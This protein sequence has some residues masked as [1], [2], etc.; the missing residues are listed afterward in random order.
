MNLAAFKGIEDEPL[1]LLSA[2]IPQHERADTS[3][4]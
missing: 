2:S 4:F 3:H 1:L